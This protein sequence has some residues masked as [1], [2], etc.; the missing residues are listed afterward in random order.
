MD[1]VQFVALEMRPITDRPWYLIAFQLRNGRWELHNTGECRLHAA[2]LEKGYIAGEWR[3]AKAAE[4]M[5]RT[6]SASVRDAGCTV[7]PARPDR[8]GSPMIAWR[9]T[10]VKVVV[11]VPRTEDGSCSM[12][13]APTTIDL[14]NRSATGDSWTP[15]TSRRGTRARRPLD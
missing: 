2:P 11:P 13:P 3:L 7:S 6:L 5:D 15:P 9:W 4:P 10:D 1:E 14:G 8:I 12:G